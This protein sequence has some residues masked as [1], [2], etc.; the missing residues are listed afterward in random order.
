MR[1]CILLI[2]MADSVHTLRWLQM[3]N[4]EGAAVILVPATERP[5]LPDI[6]AW[7][8]VRSQEDVQSLP[9]GQ[10][11]VWRERAVA[12]PEAT[13]DLLPLPVG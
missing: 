7:P 13:D 12:P 10:I 6:A 2:A 1:R 9:S 11:G 4:W 3:V 8:A 5:S